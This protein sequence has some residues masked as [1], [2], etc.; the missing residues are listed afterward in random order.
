MS[1]LPA[2]VVVEGGATTLGDNRRAVEAALDAYAGLDILVSTVGVF[3]FYRGID[4]LDEDV[5]EAAFEEMFAT[6]VRS[7]LCGVKAALP[8]LE[9]SGGNVVLTASTSSF[10]PGRGGVLYVSSKFAVRGLVIALA[11]EL[12]PGSASTPSPPAARWGPICAG[13]PRSTWGSNGSTIE[14]ARRRARAADS[15]GGG[16]RAGRPREELRVPR[17]RSSPWDHGDVRPSRRRDRR[18]GMTRSLTTRAMSRDDRPTDLGPVPQ[19]PIE[20]VDNA[21][22]V[23]LLLDERPELRL[24]EVSEHLGVASSTAHRLLAMLQ[25]RGFVHQD[26]ATKAYRPGPALTRIAFSVLERLDAPRSAPSSSGSTASCGR[27]STSARCS[28]PRCSSSMRSRARRP[29]V[30]PLGSEGRCPRARPRPGRRC[31][32][33]CRTSRS[34]SCTPTMTS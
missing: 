20:S 21:L 23:L 8:A 25:Y 2:S 24:T 10:F 22:K 5:L 18:Q 34:P 30:S 31:S 3:D 33:S 15:V 9:A 4:E 17:F 7:Q 29:S 13:S 32:P 11:H 12:A 19:Y 28:E 6:N 16:A 1:A 14:R 26:R 27:R